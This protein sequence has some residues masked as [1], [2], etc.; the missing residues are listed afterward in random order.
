[1]VN[2]FDAVGR[3]EFRAASALPYHVAVGVVALHC[4]FT[5]IN[6]NFSGGSV[7]A[8][9]SEFVLCEDPI[10][11]LLELLGKGLERF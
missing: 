3:Q 1:M 11:I 5:R 2:Q 7:D 8:G 10:P 4:R 9:K 6:E